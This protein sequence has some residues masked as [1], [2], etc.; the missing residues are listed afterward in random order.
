M[1]QENVEIVRR[2]YEESAHGRFTTCLHLFHPE[3]EYTR[4]G[5]AAVGLTGHWRGI[6]PML[7]AAYEWVQTF[8]L[9]RVEAE[10]FIEAGDSVVVF[11]RQRGRAKGSGV[12]IDGEFTDVLTLRDGLVVRFAQYRDRA[13]ALA[14][15]G[16]PN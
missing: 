5:D 9:L 3:V 2:I 13:A 10:E 6:E 12:P 1:S 14:S 15:V 11:T 7:R 16:L 4:S 8:D